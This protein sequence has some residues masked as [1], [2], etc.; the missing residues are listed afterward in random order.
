[1]DFFQDTP[2]G[3]V[4]QHRI[5]GLFQIPTQPLGGLLGGT[6]KPSK[7]AILAAARKKKEEEKRQSETGTTPEES[8]RTISLLDRL[9]S[10]KDIGRPSAP[11]LNKPEQR[12]AE[13]EQPTFTVPARAKRQS[14]HIQEA[15]VKPTEASEVTEPPPKR[16]AIQDLRAPPSAFAQALLGYLGSDGGAVLD[17]QSAVSTNGP[18]RSLSFTLPFLDSVEQFPTSPFAGPSP[19]D[20]V[21]AAQSKGSFILK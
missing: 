13:P 1:M 9:G 11:T 20:I 5:G 10:K 2:W 4:P 7:L 19:D 17:L 18:L 6:S 8:S 21:L 15:P 14:S 16:R 3:R 12:R